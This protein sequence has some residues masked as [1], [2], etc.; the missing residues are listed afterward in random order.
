VKEYI[1]TIKPDRDELVNHIVWLMRLT[2]K[3][4]TV[5]VKMLGELHRP[6]YWLKRGEY[7]EEVYTMF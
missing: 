1:T 6:D 2:P 5:I 3:Q 7:V 4:A